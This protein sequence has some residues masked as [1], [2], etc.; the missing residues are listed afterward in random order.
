MNALWYKHGAISVMKNVC[1]AVGSISKWPNLCRVPL[2]G[3][4]ADPLLLLCP[5]SSLAPWLHVCHFLFLFRSSFS[6]S[7]PVL[8]CVAALLR[9]P[10]RAPPSSHPLLPLSHLFP[11]PTHLP[12]VLC[13]PPS[14]EDA[15][16]F[17]CQSCFLLPL[18]PPYLPFFDA[19][20]PNCPPRPPA[21]PFSF[22]AFLPDWRR[23]FSAISRRPTLPRHAHPILL[24]SVPS[25]LLLPFHRPSLPLFL[26]ILPLILLIFIIVL[27]AR[28]FLSAST[29]FISRG[30]AEGSGESLG[31]SG[32]TPGHV[33]QV[34][35]QVPHARSSSQGS[36]DRALRFVPGHQALPISR[37]ALS[38]KLCRSCL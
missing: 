10:R 5:R 30:S 36:E 35:Q 21:N 2:P 27:I 24:I 19:F 28:F 7:F 13:T 38:V 1:T 11:P 17:H 32:A 26:L 23:H 14:F 3:P 16:T 22:S 33:Q 15:F 37:L 12:F 29:A 34:P 25:P 8:S 31:G 9:L 4:R 20:L 6:L 18:P